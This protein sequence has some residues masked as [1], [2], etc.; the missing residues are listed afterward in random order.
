MSEHLFPS[1][2]AEIS[3][4]L[5]SR[6]FRNLFEHT[7]QPATLLEDGVIVEANQASVDLF[8]RKT[9]DEL[10]GLSAIELSP[11]RQENGQLSVELAEENIRR[12]LEEGRSEL[13]WECIRKNGERFFIHLNL[14]VVK[15]GER[16]LLYAVYNDISRQK[17]AE[18]KLQASEMR[19]RNLFEATRQATIL[20]ENGK[21][22]L[23]NKASADLLGVAGP[24]KLVGLSPLDVSPQVQPDGSSS[25]DK[26]LEVTG[27]AIAEGSNEV[28]WECIRGDGN[29]IFIR[30]LLTRIEIGG[31]LVI[32]S[33][34]N[35]ITEEKKARDRI[36]F[37]A[38]NH[39]RT[40]LPNRLM[41]F[42]MLDALLKVT[43]DTNSKAAVLLIS[44]DTFRSV[45]NLQGRKI[46]EELEVH[47]GRVLG[48][49]LR[50]GD[51]LYH[52]ETAEFLLVLP[53]ATIPQVENL[54][55]RIR[56]RFDE[57]FMIDGVQIIAPVSI[58][59]AMSPEDGLDSETLVGHADIALSETRRLA[60]NSF[61][62]YTRTMGA[63]QNRLALIRNQLREAITREEFILHYQPKIDIRT[64]Q[65]SGAEALIR[66]NH[67]ERSLL[68]PGEFLDVAEATGLIVP[69][70]RWILMEACRQA[71]EWRTHGL[72]DVK[73]AVNLS[74]EHFYQRLVEKDVQE[75]LSESGL[76]P[77]LLELEL[78]ESILLENEH[79][80]ISLLETWHSMGIQL[81]ID[82]FGTGYSSLAYLS[83]FP[84]DGLKIDRSFILAFEDGSR[85]ESIVRAIIELGKALDLK[86]IAEGVESAEMIDRLRDMGC[87]EVQ[88]Y[89]Y[90]KPLSADE[91]EK[92]VR[93]MKEGSGVLNP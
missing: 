29:H 26:M 91:F 92:W 73:V 21:F 37:L 44:L 36:E 93:R 8:G 82:D 39:E 60:G 38:Y 59:I 9:P 47:A 62:F 57:P 17:E 74:A 15:V 45:R 68:M 33:V 77:S 64:G 53:E 30:L 35:D 7:S 32:H 3:S 80:I 58:G 43:S 50:A 69:M 76:P 48:D 55:Q 25:T 87:D 71:E 72:Q 46:S 65:L 42:Q 34:F 10:F 11:E 23:A 16:T 90:A 61:L 78:T 14:T 6:I 20:V 40:G 28:E 4:S 27:K 2:N 51:S 31:S 85:G 56:T 66:W 81:S 84:I 79:D 19:F 83:R 89:I 24:E 22:I 49:S 52:L 1:G 88:G 41:G 67:P 86:L 70:S 18:R 63:A 5:S 54:C 12:T 75:A 13:D